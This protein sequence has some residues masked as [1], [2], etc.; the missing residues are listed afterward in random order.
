LL[1]NVGAEHV[2]AVNALLARTEHAVVDVRSYDTKQMWDPENSEFTHEV[3][4]LV[5]ARA[6]RLLHQDWQTEV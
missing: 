5:L 4:P 6:A 1:V 3:A 2:T